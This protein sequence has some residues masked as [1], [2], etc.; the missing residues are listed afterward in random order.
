MSYGP[1]ALATGLEQ[2]QLVIEYAELFCNHINQKFA[3]ASETIDVLNRQVLKELPQRNCTSIQEFH[4]FYERRY[5]KHL[6]GKIDLRDRVVNEANTL[7]IMVNWWWPWC[8]ALPEQMQR[9]MLMMAVYEKVKDDEE[10][11]LD[12][13]RAVNEL[14][15]SSYGTFKFESTSDCE[16]ELDRNEDFD[17]TTNA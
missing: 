11:L 14:C 9:R 5:P 8:I 13:Y 17:E 7:A 3:A 15:E 6:G 4:A 1:V 2:A 10:Y 16:E 12:T